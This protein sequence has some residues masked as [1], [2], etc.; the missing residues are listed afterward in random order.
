MSDEAESRFEDR[1]LDSV[2]VK[3][4]CEVEVAVSK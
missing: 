3:E 1:E 2:E 4:S